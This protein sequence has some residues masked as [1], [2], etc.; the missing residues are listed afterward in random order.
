MKQGTE[1]WFE[2]RKGK[3]TASHAQAIGT[4]G[5]GL[6]TYCESVAC[7]LFSN[8]TERFSNEHTDRGNE[9]E[10]QA[11]ALYEL[12][13][14]QQVTE[15]GFIDCG[16]C[17]C[18]PDGLVGENGGIEIKCLDDKNHFHVLITE[19]IPSAYEWQVQM[20]LFVTRRKW[21]DVV[22]FNP[23]FERDL[24]IIRVKPD[25]DKFEKLG[26]GIEAGA[27]LIQELRKKYEKDQ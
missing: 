24:Y 7:E 22:F 9:L 13:T 27:N 6:Q 1:E 4:N 12:E 23:N 2:A 3:L 11:R 10:P 14:G 17:G 5:K 21:W 20:N 26:K 25:G 15:V 16:A 18:S 8:S 19:K